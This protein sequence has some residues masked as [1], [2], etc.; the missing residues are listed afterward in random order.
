MGT[1][2]GTCLTRR[3]TRERADLLGRGRSLPPYCP[4][5]PNRF[6]GTWQNIMNVGPWWCALRINLQTYFTNPRLVINQNIHPKI[7]WNW[8]KTQCEHCT[9]GSGGLMDKSSGASKWTGL[10][11]IC[12]KYVL[13]IRSPVHIHNS[14]AFTIVNSLILTGY[15]L[16]AKFKRSWFV[17]NLHDIHETNWLLVSDKPNSLSQIFQQN[18]K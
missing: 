1:W 5:S 18:G 9:L 17:Q 14:S 3:S 10:D 13:L 8:T 6:V 2:I 15:A 11:W 12:H 7:R 16:F 4:H